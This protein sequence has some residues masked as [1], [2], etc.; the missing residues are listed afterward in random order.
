MTN[1]KQGISPNSAELAQHLIEQGYSIFPVGKD[2]KPHNGY[3]WGDHPITSVN[4]ANLRW[5]GANKGAGVGVITGKDSNLLVLDV[6]NKNGVSGSA[7]LEELEAQHGSLPDT[8]TVRTPSG[9]FHYYFNYN[10]CGLTVGAGIMKGLDYRGSGG[11]VVSAGSVTERGAYTVVK[12]SPVADAPSWLINVLKRDS[13][14]SISN[15]NTNT[16]TFLAEGGRN[17]ALTSIAGTMRRK[18]MEQE[19][20]E[21]YLLAMNAALPESLSEGEVCS[22]AK[23]VAKYDPSDI[24]VYANEQDFADILAKEWEGK[25][26][27]VPALG[28]IINDN[29]VWT[30]DVE[31]LS[32]K[33]LIQNAATKAHNELEKIATIQKD[34]KQSKATRVTRF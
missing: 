12:D 20:I 17:N 8:F 23:S 31:A 15:Q 32:V 18:G 27:Y 26:R 6:D 3:K 1:T 4:E 21:E 14:V 7:S 11:F 33:R 13:S 9:G 34:A 30:R 29:D 10:N 19:E 22:I 16:S 25:I 5:S 2:K 24:S 28:F